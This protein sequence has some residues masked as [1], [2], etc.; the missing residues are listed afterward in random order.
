M[1]KVLKI[2][3]LSLRDGQQSSFATRM[4]QEQINRCLPYY[5]DAGFYAMEVWHAHGEHTPLH[6]HLSRACSG[7]VGI[8]QYLGRFGNIRALMPSAEADL[9]RQN[10]PADGHISLL[11]RTHLQ[12]LDVSVEC[13]AQI[14]QAFEVEIQVLRVVIIFRHFFQR[15]SERLQRTDRADLGHIIRRIIA[16]SALLILDCRREKSHIFINQQRLSGNAHE[17]R[18]FADLKQGCVVFFHREPPLGY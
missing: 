15:Q 12:H 1:A 3:D 2:R 16:V 5:K 4:T 8:A 11:G 17:F 13:F 6:G 18:H 10:S 14:R 7:D 9:L